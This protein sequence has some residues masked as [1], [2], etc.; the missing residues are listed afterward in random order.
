MRVNGVDIDPSGRDRSDFGLS[1]RV[2]EAGGVPPDEM[3]AS[4]LTGASSALSVSRASLVTASSVV[5]A[6]LSSACCWLPLVLVAT[7]LSAGGLSL[8]FASLRP[9][10]IGLAVALLAFGVWSNERRPRTPVSCECAPIPRRRRK[11][12]RVVLAI[13]ALGVVAFTVFPRYVDAVFGE[14]SSPV[15]TRAPR[16]ITL[17]VDGMTCTG[18]E[19]GI[20]AALRRLPGVALA[21][22]SYNDGTVVI[23]LAPDVTIGTNDLIQAIAQAGYSAQADKPAPPPKPAATPSTSLRVLNGELDPLTA[24]FNA[25]STRVRFVAILSPT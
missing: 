16:E 3:I 21:E 13:S 20:E 2:Y 22:A 7:G 17:R 9:W 12:N 15:S 10:L 23:G 11:L 8:A 5:A 19:T 14:R 1:C 6:A 4:A 24:H 25:A 18:C